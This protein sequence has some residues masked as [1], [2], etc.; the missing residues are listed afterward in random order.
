MSLDAYEIFLAVVREKSF[1]RAA[2]RV[3]LTPS[4]V[5]HAI[6]RLEQRFGAQLFVRGKHEV[7]LTGAGEHLLPFIADVLQKET[8][9]TQEVDFMLGNERGTVRLGTFSSVCSHWIP[10]LMKAFRREHPQ[11]SVVVFQGGYDDIDNWVRT[12]AIDLAFVSRSFDSGKHVTPLCRDRLVCVAPYD[13]VP[14]HGDTVTFEDFSRNQL[15]AQQGINNVETERFLSEYGIELNSQFRIEDD[16]SL[17]AMVES[18]FG[19]C[20]LQ[21]LV[22]KNIHSHVKIYPI[23][24]TTYRELGIK[25]VDP[26]SC[27]PAARLLHDFIVSRADALAR[28]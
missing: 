18:G 11:I 22:V 4:A 3:S 25:L 24:P 26:V 8:L 17:V 2:N 9:L 23:E 7:S 10:F 21:E 12:R 1:L 5:S 14:V 16:R 20:L 13:Y 28:L 6:A 19:L 27:P 15:I